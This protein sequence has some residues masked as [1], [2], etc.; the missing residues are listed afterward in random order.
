[1]K[2]GKILVIALSPNPGELPAEFAEWFAQVRT[3]LVE[4]LNMNFDAWQAQFPYD[5]QLAFW[6][7]ADP[8]T[9]AESANRHYWEAQL[10]ARPDIAAKFHQA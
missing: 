2:A 6:A 3:V 7:G 1:M 8:D 9:T 4:R 5:F 10:K